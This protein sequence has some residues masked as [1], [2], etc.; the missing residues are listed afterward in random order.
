[1]S[2]NRFLR[3][4]WGALLVAL[5]FVFVALAAAF[6]GGVVFTTEH[7]SDWAIAL[8]LFMAL[9]FA[10]CLFGIAL[11]RSLLSPVITRVRWAR[12]EERMKPRGFR[13]ASP[14]EA[15]EAARIPIY[16]LHPVVLAPER[17]GGVSH[18]LVGEVF[19]V[20]ALAFNVTVRGGGWHDVTVAAV[21][22]DPSC[23]TTMIR[24]RLGPAIRPHPEM[25]T[26]RLELERFNRGVTVHSTEPYFA[27]AILD[28]R[29]MEWL[30]SNLGALAVEL[31][32]GW[33]VA[34][35][36]RPT[37][38]GGDPGHLLDFLIGFNR[39][40]PR[41]IPSLFPDPDRP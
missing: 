39:S 15:G 22:I 14:S 5:L 12:F 26:V 23:P 36:L 29:M 28:Q 9:A 30:R 41:A 8:V 19:G 3:A 16:L 6:M 38:A 21:R 40:I 17:G 33:A 11:L 24:P 27:T 25:Q 31:G 10:A 34:W 18:V 4:S 13:K 37:G 20:Q 7:D 32:G 1:M 2:T 35:R